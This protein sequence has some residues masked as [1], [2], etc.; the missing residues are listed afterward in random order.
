MLGESIPDWLLKGGTV[1]L[2]NF[3]RNKSDPLVV[4]VELLDA[5]PKYALIRRENG[6]ESTVSVR[7]LA[8]CPSSGVEST[9]DVRPQF[10]PLPEIAT[11]ESEPAADKQTSDESNNRETSIDESPLDVETQAPLRRSGRIRRAPERYGEWTN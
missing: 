4:E 6:M 1:L 8:H 7:D 9:L 11:P 5:N 2:R 10:E 3:I